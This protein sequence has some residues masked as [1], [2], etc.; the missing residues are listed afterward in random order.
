MDGKGSRGIQAVYNLAKEQMEVYEDS[1][2][3][4]EFQLE[5]I[6]N[7]YKGVYEQLFED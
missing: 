1:D 5:R 6:I 7:L 2:P 3:K 4:D